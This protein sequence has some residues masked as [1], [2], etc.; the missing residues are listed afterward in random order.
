VPSSFSKRW[1]QVER[2]IL[3]EWPA[4]RCSPHEGQPRPWRSLSIVVTTTELGLIT[5]AVVGTAAALSPAF[6]AWANR[7]HERAMAVSSRRFDQRRDTYREV[8]GFL[9]RQR[10]MFRRS[11]QGVL[12]GQ[13]PKDLSDEELTSLL[14]RA[15]IDGSP[16]VNAKLDLY[17]RAAGAYFPP[18]AAFEAFERR[19]VEKGELALPPP[20][21][22]EAQAAVAEAR[23]RAIEAIDAVEAAMRDELASL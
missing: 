21:W 7:Q 4:C 3:G 13:P 18:L 15:A 20:G 8:A 11:S 1:A 6:T 12:G 16:D 2:V 9:E 5:T 22:M 19:R 10:V 23:D 17:T 14:G